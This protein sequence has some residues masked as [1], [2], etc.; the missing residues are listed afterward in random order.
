MFNEVKIGRNKQLEV[1][2][3]GFKS[4]NRKSRSTRQESQGFRSGNQ[5]NPQIITTGDQSNA[6]HTH[7][8]SLGT[9]GPGSAIGSQDKI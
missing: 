6:V 2:Q 1:G 4:G 9:G 5:V 3:D 8:A 7:H